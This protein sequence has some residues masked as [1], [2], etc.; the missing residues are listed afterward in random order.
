MIEDDS[1]PRLHYHIPTDPSYARYARA[2]GKY[3]V[4]LVN[5][6]CLFSV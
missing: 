2:F 5:K 3:S 6:V 4:G 1:N